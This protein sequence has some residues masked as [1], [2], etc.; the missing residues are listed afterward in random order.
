LQ[1]VLTMIICGL[2]CI[3][4]SR[5]AWRPS[6]YGHNFATTDSYLN[7]A[8][9]SQKVSSIQISKYFGSIAC[10]AY[11]AL[12]SVAPDHRQSFSY[13]TAIYF[14]G[15]TACSNQLFGFP[16]HLLLSICHIFEFPIGIY[17]TSP[18]RLL[19]LLVNHSTHP[20]RNAKGGATYSCHN[21]KKCPSF[22]E[23]R[24]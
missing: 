22:A 21:G 8:P 2:R 1:P 3:D 23:F 24:C 12:I 5:A 7:V 13:R 14:V 4:H 10:T 6:W 20:C 19:I 16:M 11:L 15:M 17:H 18:V 9:S